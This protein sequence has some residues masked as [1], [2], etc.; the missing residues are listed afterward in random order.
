[1]REAFVRVSGDALD[2][3]IGQQRIAWGNSDAFRPNDVVNARDLRDRAVRES[4]IEHV[5][6]F[7]V[8]G[9]VALSDVT[10]TLIAAP[11]FTPDRL[12]IYGSN[13]A[14]IQP[15]A[16]AAFVRLATIASELIDD[17]L[18]DR[19][20]PVLGQ[21]RIPADFWEGAGA[22]AALRW[23]AGAV[24]LSHYYQFGHDRAPSL[25]LDASLA[26]RL[27][28]ID[29]ENPFNDATLG[30]IN[31]IE[32]AQRADEDLLSA[33]YVRSHHFG[34][35]VQTAAGPIVVRADAAFDTKR[36]YYERAT[37]EGISLPTAELVL[38]LEYH[39][40]SDLVLTLEG[41]YQWIFDAPSDS[42]LLGYERATQS[43]AQITRW[44]NEDFEAES[45]IVCGVRPRSLIVQPELGY[46]PGNWSIRL[47]L[48]ALIGEAGS[49]AEY[50]DRNSTAYVLA[51]VSL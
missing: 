6:T 40:S 48:L 43:V 13:W 32:R 45:R 50:Y 20:Q 15:G 31:E 16:P 39:V 4:E 11:F 9:D 26:E 22:A 7:S 44:S 19:A 10:L 12:D 8:R 25:H 2:L 23:S 18:R 3:T 24:D 35:D 17:T 1:V 14:L 33:T 21:T 51:R 34:T 49:W 47:G 37:L 42:V 36:V 41:A 38:G 29:P 46:T 30:L 27:A 5:P 28:T